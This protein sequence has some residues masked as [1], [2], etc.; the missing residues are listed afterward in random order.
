MGDWGEPSY[1]LP[2]MTRWPLRIVVLGAASLRQAALDPKMPL[3]F[4]REPDSL[5]GALLPRWDSPP[6]AGDW[7]RVPAV[8]LKFRGCQDLLRCAALATHF[9]SPPHQ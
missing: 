6:K 4:P 3:L 2:R 8:R 7:P 9:G 5:A 1:F